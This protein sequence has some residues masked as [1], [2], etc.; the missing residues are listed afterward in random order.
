MDYGQ[1]SRLLGDSEDPGNLSLSDLLGEQ[2]PMQLAGNGISFQTQRAINQLDRDLAGPPPVVPSPG[3]GASGQD[4]Q[5]T[6]DWR[7]RV[8]PN[9]QQQLEELLRRRRL[10]EQHLKSQ[11]RSSLSDLVDYQS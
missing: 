10:L 11:R 3:V 9:Q 6:Q 5:M 8:A 4:N 1:L 7:N 2:P